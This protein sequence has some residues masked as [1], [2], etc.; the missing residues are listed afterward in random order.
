MQ[1]VNISNK[2]FIDLKSFFKSL[3]LKYCP[4][5]LFDM[6]DRNV[7]KR[8]EKIRTLTEKEKT[9]KDLYAHLLSYKG[10]MERKK[11]LLTISFISYKI[12]YGL[13]A[14][15]DFYIDDFVGEFCGTVTSNYDESS[16]N[17]G[18]NYFSAVNIIGHDNDDS[19]ILIAPRKIGNELQFANHSSNKNNVKWETI[20]GNDDRYHVIFVA[21][22]NIKKGEQILVDYGEEYWQILGIN[23]VDI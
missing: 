7:K 16:R 6:A 17:Y 18:Y 19:D 14:G 22:T 23:P 5:L 11:P 15:Q 1:N 12:G 8:V 10:Q 9:K 13:F 21:T 20:I 4:Y 3:G 2:N